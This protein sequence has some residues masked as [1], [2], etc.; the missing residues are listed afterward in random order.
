MM[1]LATLALLLALLTGAPASAQYVMGFEDVPLAPGL[2]MVGGSDM[3]FDKPEGRIIEATAHGA[4][5]RRKVVEFYRGSLHQ[6]GWVEAGSSPGRL[7]FQRE[8]ERLGISFAGR[9]GALDVR[10]QLSPAAGKR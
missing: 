7:Q 2:A 3:H 10:Y 4:T 6:L 5:D 1:R 9:D 8:D